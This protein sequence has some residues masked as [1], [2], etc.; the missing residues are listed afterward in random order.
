MHVLL[1]D[2]VLGLALGAGFFGL[3]ALWGWW[4]RRTLLRPPEL[5]EDV[6]CCPVCGWRPCLDSCRLG[7]SAADLEELSAPFEESTDGA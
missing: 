2:L 6:R 4:R 7:L 1:Q 5:V 3:P